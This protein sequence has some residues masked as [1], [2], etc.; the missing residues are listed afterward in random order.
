MQ[1]HG[2]GLELVEVASGFQLRTKERYAKAL[3]ALKESRPKKLSPPA[4]E[5]LAIV[6]YRQPIVKSDVEAIRGVDATPTLKTL[7]QRR[8]IRIV[9]HQA[10]AG[11]PALYG[12][13]DSFLE[14]FGLK[15]LSE[16]P[17]LRDLQELD[18]APQDDI[19]DEIEEGEEGTEGHAEEEVVAQQH[20]VE[21]D[22]EHQS[23]QEVSEASDTA[24]NM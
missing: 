24:A 13:T 17:T 1:E 3:Q 6:A 10:T 11:Q 19:E 12:T 7:L 4:L 9:G 8:L 2:S 18:Q 22:V 15:S 16:L 20:D 5:T 21:N 14:L 23:E